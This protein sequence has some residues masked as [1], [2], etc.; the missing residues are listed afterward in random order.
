MLGFGGKY[1]WFYCFSILCMKKVEK[2]NLEKEMENELRK[3]FYVMLRLWIL[4][5]GWLEV[6]VGFWVGMI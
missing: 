1:V 4:F 5:L 6:V 3:V 2:W